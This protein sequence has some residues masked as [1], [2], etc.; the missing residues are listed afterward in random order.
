MGVIH[1]VKPRGCPGLGAPGH[2]AVPLPSLL[3]SLLPRLPRELLSHRWSPS[4][5]PLRLPGPVLPTL[6]H[7]KA[8][9]VFGYIYIK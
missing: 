2:P 8:V 5:L 9:M 6:S 7:P 1:S 4:I 3:P